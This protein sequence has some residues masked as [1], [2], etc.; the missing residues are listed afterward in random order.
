MED[1]IESLLKIHVPELYELLLLPAG[2]AARKNAFVLQ[3]GASCRRRRAIEI[4]MDELPRRS[5]LVVVG[6]LIIVLEL[7]APCFWLRS[8]IGER[9]HLLGAAHFIQ[10]IFVAILM[11]V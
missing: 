4:H 7:N 11:N 6:C 9:V 3:I 1:M 8:S 10:L 5:L 2:V